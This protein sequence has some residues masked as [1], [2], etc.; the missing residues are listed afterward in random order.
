MT[1]DVRIV[2]NRFGTFARQI[3]DTYAAIVKA[4]ALDIAADA[5]AAAP[6]GYTHHADRTLRN[7]ITH[8]RDSAGRTWVYTPNWYAA[9]VE[10]GAMQ[11]GGAAARPF[12]TPA[13]EKARPEFQAACRRLERHLR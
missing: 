5:A 13:A 2:S 7:S 10:Y 9:L 11:G 6:V 8:G 1:V 4:T 3:P 12:L